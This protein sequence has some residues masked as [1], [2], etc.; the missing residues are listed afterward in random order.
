MEQRYFR[1]LGALS[2]EECRILQKK[3]IF[4]AGCGGLGGHVTDMLLRIGVGGIRAV[5]GDVFDESNLNRQLLSNVARIGTPKAAAAAEHAALVNPSVRFEAEQCFI[6]AE[7]AA[8]LL[9]GCDIAI[10]ALDNIPS[11]R[12]LAKACS[13]AGIPFV[14][15]A[16]NGWLAQA[17]LI[18]PGSSVLDLIYPPEACDFDASSAESG[19]APEKPQSRQNG[20]EESAPAP[21]KSVLAFT[22]ALCAAM[23]V[24]LCIKQLCSRETEPGKLFIFDLETMDFEDVQL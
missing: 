9:S 8:D 23:E 5:D 13:E 12:V 18:L 3:K 24:S 10:D 6:T 17:C 4:V 15:G 21:G 16:I 14:H 22:P 20:A 19:N 11:R 2:E 7:N 1:N